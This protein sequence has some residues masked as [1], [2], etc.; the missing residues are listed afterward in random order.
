MRNQLKK[1]MS[2]LSIFASR[3]HSKQAVTENKEV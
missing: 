2:R 1:K 3:G